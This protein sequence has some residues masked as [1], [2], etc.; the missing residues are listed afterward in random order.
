MT[1]EKKEKMTALIPSVGADGGQSPL[2]NETIL[3]DNQQDGNHQSVEMEEM[4][5]WLRQMRQM[6]SPDYLH[7]VSLTELYDTVYRSRMPVIENLLYTGAYIL[8]GAP[9]IGKSFLVAQ[10]A[11][12][13]ST[14]QPIW[15][16]EIKQPGA[17]LYLALEDDYQRLQE[18][19]A[20]MFGVESD[21][22]LFFAVSA[23]QVG[24]GLDEQLAFFLREHPNTR[25]VI[26]D[27]LQKVREMSGDAYSY[28]GDYEIISRLKAFGEQHGVCVLIVHHTR[29]QPAGDSFE[30]ISGTTGLL[31][32]ADGAIL[33][34]K[35]KRTDNKAALDIVGRDQPDQKIYLIRD[36]VTLQWNFEKAERQLWKEPPDPILMAV[37]KLVTVKCPQWKGSATELAEALRLSIQPNALSKKLNVKAG[38]LMQEFGIRYENNRSRT[39]SNITLT[40]VTTETTGEECTKI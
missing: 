12:H 38:K 30:T 16:Y 11:H 19:M 18:R 36:E 21:G 3:T 29:K 35:E 25:L 2:C 20:R 7:T 14:G 37:A 6:N 31:G 13:V 27:T 32:C 15:E 8:A 4:E 5:A 22:E 33:M 39:G 1:D 10:F 17:V 9:K 26:V 28:A 40:L 24:N 34:Q 23:K